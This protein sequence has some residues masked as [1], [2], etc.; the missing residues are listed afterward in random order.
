MFSVVPRK[1]ADF[2]GRSLGGLLYLLLPGKRQLTRQSLQLSFPEWP[3]AQVKSVSKK[4]FHTQGLFFTEI[5]RML[6]HA[7]PSPLEMIDCDPALFASMS[8]LYAQGRGVLVL[9]AHINNYELLLTW[10]ARHFPMTV[11][12]KRI[13]PE[14]LN[15]FF[16]AKR[17][18]DRINVLPAR[19]SYRGIFKALKDGGCVGFVMDQNMKHDE[20]VFVT[21][22]G[23]PACTTPG[24]AM[25]SAHAQAPVLPVCL[26]RNGDRY[27]LKAF[28]VMAPPPDREIKTLHDATQR[29]SNVIEQM[30][31]EQPEAWIWMH[32]RWKTPPKK[33]DR[34]TLNDGS[35][36]HV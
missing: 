31:R 24:L 23:R 9:T 2:L 16:I 35:E 17:K 19:G 36:R 14:S 10:A 26:I 20:G 34:I 22:F 21:F 11:V 29:Y 1:V 18:A 4:V 13:R 6:G 25:L 7:K 15:D 3:P 8:E 28:P 32:K 30:I 33:G 27:T 5:L 12:T